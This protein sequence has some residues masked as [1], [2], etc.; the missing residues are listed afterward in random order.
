MNFPPLNSINDI[1][2][3]TGLGH[4][5]IYELIGGK[6][7]DARKVGAKTLITGASLEAFIAGLPVAPM[8]AKREK[9]AA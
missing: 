7:L 2:R 4:T 3:L 6:M 1:K 9:V 8:R 5:K